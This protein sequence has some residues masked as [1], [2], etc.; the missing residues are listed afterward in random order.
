MGDA[1]TIGITLALENGVSEG[2]AVIRRDLQSLDVAIG[3]T[4]GGLAGLRRA[5]DLGVSFAGPDLARVVAEGHRA[6]GRLPAL[7]PPIPS[8]RPRPSLPDQNET[9]PPNGQSVP[10]IPSAGA[11]HMPG[12]P[13]RIQPAPAAAPNPVLS[14]PALGPV[15]FPG[16]ASSAPAKAATPAISIVS[17]PLAAPMTG[18]TVRVQPISAPIRPAA[19]LAV[20]PSSMAPLPIAM[21]LRAAKPVVVPERPMVP[22]PS[23]VPLPRGL[24]T[25]KLAELVRDMMPW[26]HQSPALAQLPALASPRILRSDSVTGQQHDSSEA[27]KQLP[28]LVSASARHVKGRVF[29]VA[30]PAGLRRSSAP[31]LS[32]VHASLSN[33][34]TAVPQQPASS[35]FPASTRAADGPEVGNIYLDGHLV[36]RWMS[37]RLTREAE[38]APVGPTGFD[39]RASRIWPGMATQS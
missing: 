31:S 34:A 2:I 18:P 14:A 29:D 23:S 32:Y 24:G 20:P 9:S 5:G 7:M 39:P 30:E 33:P 6:L 8:A 10:P 19:N 22:E 25:E 37:D 12:A 35:N 28:K 11:G 21:S 13:P 15:S 17:V 1:Y 26:P 16:S 36:G 3:Q 27:S 38:R 4:M